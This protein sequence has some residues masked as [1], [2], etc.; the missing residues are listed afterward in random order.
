MI[1]KSVRVRNFRCIKDETLHCDS[2]T[3]LV[4]PNGSGKS[5][6]LKAVNKFY[7]PAAKIAQ[8]DFYGNDQ[9]PI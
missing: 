6:F 8:E 3:A 4:G 5:T 9:S 7:E 1:I 2:L